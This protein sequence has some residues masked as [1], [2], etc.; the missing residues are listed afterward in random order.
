MP[1]L[2]V[3]VAE[4]IPLKKILVQLVVIGRAAREIHWAAG[5]QVLEK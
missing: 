3:L 4:P 5:N 1:A 2:P